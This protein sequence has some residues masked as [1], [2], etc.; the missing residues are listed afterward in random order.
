MV[1]EKI[2]TEPKEIANAFNN[3]FSTVAFEITLIIIYLIPLRFHSLSVHLVN[4]NSV[5]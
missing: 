3:Y 1:K 5:T 2:I 4:R